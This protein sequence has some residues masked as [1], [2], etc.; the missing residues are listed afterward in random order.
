MAE[1]SSQGSGHGDKGGK[2]KT[3]K[4]STR[5]DMTP[6]VDLGFLLITFFILTTTLIKPQTMEISVPSKKNTEKPPELKNSLAITILPGKN[7]VVYYYFGAPK[8]GVDPEVTKSDFSPTGLRKMLLERNATVY[9]KVM[10]LKKKNEARQLAD[11]TFKKEAALARADQ[12]SP[13]VIIKATD[14]ASY[15]NLVDVLDEMQIC[16][17]GRYAIVDISPYDLKL[18]QKAGEP[19]E[20]A[21]AEL[22]N[23]LN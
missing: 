22:V 18:L 9:Q 20:P 10:E 4:I 16:N 17:V 8:D 3:K 1:I 14:E 7:D 2:P 23:K 6:M 11:S 19:L 15:K 12:N 5:I 21:E 13:M